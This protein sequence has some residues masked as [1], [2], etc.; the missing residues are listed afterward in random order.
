LQSAAATPPAKALSLA[1]AW[2]VHLLTAS[3]ALLGMLSLVEIA[4]GELAIA[5][6]LM[7][8]A[9]F[10][11]SIDGSLARRARVS[12]VVPSIDGRRLDDVVD[13]LNYVIV[14]VFFMVWIGALPVSLAAAP[15]LAS[16]YGFS[17]QDAKTDDDFFLGWPSYWNVVALYAWQLEM[18][19]TTGALWVLF[20]SAA[21]F[22]PLKYIYPS[23][24]RAFRRS[25]VAGA[26]LWMILMALAVAWPGAK[27]L[28]LAEISLL[29]PAWYVLLSAHL[30]RW[31][32]S[33][34]ACRRRA[35]D[36]CWCSSARRTRRRPA[37]SAATSPSSSPT[38]A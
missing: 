4:R 31:G 14:P 23:K 34:R 12:E 18:S 27:A 37:P 19:P 2:C 30:G 22:V 20:F 9:L 17:Q 8:I 15:V 28:H 35:S 24:L 38:R 29:Y 1:L 5:S 32:R 11:D 13:Y 3:G 26:G 36:C 16:A 33:V 25:S 7:L 6:I 10:V 21:I